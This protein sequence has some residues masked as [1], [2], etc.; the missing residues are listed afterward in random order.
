MDGLTGLLATRIPTYRVAIKSGTAPVRADVSA[1]ADADAVA[2]APVE[3]VKVGAVTYSFEPKVLTLRDTG[4]GTA[5]E[6]RSRIQDELMHIGKPYVPVATLVAP[7][8][9]ILTNRF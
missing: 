2:P 3:L 8:G 1:D 6:P 5:F 4:P 7:S 9:E